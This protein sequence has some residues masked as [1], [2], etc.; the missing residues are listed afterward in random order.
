MGKILSLLLMSLSVLMADA[1]MVTVS[2]LPQKFFVEKIAE[3]KI[4]VNVMVKPG[5]S[6]ATYEPKPEQ[7]KKIVSSK[8]YFSIGVPFEKVWLSKF[9]AANAQMI[10]T[11]TSNGIDKLSMASHSHHE[12]EDE[13]NTHNEGGIKDPHIWLDPILVKIQAKHIYNTLVSI[14]SNN[15]SFYRKNYNNFLRE[16]DTLNN[17]I[18][19]ILSSSKL[20]SFMVF[21]PSWGYFAKAYNLEQITVEIEGK[22]PKPAEL[23]NLIKEAK[24]E[25]IKVA[26]VQPQFSKKSISTIA[27]YINAKVEV[28]DPLAENWDKNLIYVANILKSSF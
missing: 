22:E 7:M 18:K 9:K 2:I 16:I 13:H 8:A 21:H 25:N 27:K 26:F 4:E 10:I 24:E 20:K 5:F 1:T 28:I 3:D 11:D 12:E 23:I 19:N 14:D 15:S 17:K 6:P